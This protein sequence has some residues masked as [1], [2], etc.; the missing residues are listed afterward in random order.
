MLYLRFSFRAVRQSFRYDFSIGFI[1]DP[2]Q[3]AILHLSQDVW[4][5][6]VFMTFMSQFYSQFFYDNI[7]E[8]HDSAPQAFQFYCDRIRHIDLIHF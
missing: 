6:T 3:A 7:F 4:I 5:L 2:V 1:V 8:L